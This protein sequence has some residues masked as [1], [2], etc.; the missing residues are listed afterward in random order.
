[1]RYLCGCA[2]RS[3]F[4]SA[5]TALVTR[6]VWSRSHF[7]LY[8]H[9]ANCIL[10]SPTCAYVHTGTCRTTGTI[11][12]YQWVVGPGLSRRSH[13]LLGP[14]AGNATRARAADRDGV[15]SLGL[16]DSAPPGSDRTGSTAPA[17]SAGL[18]ERR[19]RRRRFV[20]TDILRPAPAT[21]HQRSVRLVRREPN[22][23]S[24]CL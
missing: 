9:S 2:V 24:R 17:R 21:D 19:Q 6:P 13:S 4:S 1:M 23:L 15:P 12:R 7:F 14:R 11:L 10:S 22:R 5:R 8:T 18:T 20:S 16:S 3:R